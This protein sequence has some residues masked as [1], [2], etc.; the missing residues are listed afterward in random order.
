MLKVMDVERSFSSISS[1]FAAWVRIME[2]HT[3]RAEIADSGR[4]GTRVLVVSPPTDPGLRLIAEANRAGET[5][6]LCFSERL[7]R[8]ARRY[9]RRHALNSLRIEVA[10]FFEPSVADGG[11]DA[12]YANCFFDFCPDER[13]PSILGEIRR[14][15][16]VDGAVFAVNMGPPARSLNRVWAWVFRHSSLVSRGC[17]PVSTA[18]DFSRCGFVVRKDLACDRFG[19]PVRYTVAV[20]PAGGG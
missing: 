12:V 15:L 11:L 20:K 13:I 18:E 7:A 16:R 8:L 2:M 4:W 19:F 3:R 10:P 9:A 6:L 17:H 1:F 5:T 14:A